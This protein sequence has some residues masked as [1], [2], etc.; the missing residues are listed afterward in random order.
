MADKTLD[1]KGLAC[2]LPIL[3]TR[4]ALSALPK[5]ATLEVLA[6]DPGSV[7]DFRA[8]C[9]TTGNRLLEKDEADGVYRFVIEHVG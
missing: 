6:T 9:E 8:F 5:G 2:P 3:K 7:P 4:K 1:L